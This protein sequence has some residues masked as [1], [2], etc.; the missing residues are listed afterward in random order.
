MDEGPFPGHRL[1]IVSSC[2]RRGTNIQ[3]RARSDTFQPERGEGGLWRGLC[4]GWGL[5][6]EWVGSTIIA[7]CDC[8]D[9]LASYLLKNDS[10]LLLDT[11]L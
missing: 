9:N 8:G 5:Q 1:L 3:T 7:N 4:D 10:S 11:L 2:G 6:G